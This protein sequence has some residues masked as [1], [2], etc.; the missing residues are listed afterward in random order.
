MP[1]ASATPGGKPRARSNFCRANA[2]RNRGLAAILVRDTA[3]V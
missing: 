2:M 1:A 3:G